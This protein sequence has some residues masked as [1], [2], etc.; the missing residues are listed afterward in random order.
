MALACVSRRE[1]KVS[2]VR[3]LV[4][5]AGTEIIVRPVNCDSE[6][7]NRGAS[8]VGKITELRVCADV[9]DQGPTSRPIAV[10]LVRTCS[11]IIHASSLS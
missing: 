5:A 2:R 1:H 6:S 3:R 11:Q 4:I 7:I 9:Q 8:F 10:A